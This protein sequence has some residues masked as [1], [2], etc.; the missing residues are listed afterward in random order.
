MALCLSKL[1]HQAGLL[2]SVSAILGGCAIGG[3]SET[4]E[5]V[6]K[7][8]RRLYDVERKIAD[9][10][11]GKQK[12]EGAKRMTQNEARLEQLS[13]DVNQLKGEVDA[14]R[15]G[16]TMGELPGSLQG[17]DSLAKSVQDLNARLQ[18]MEARQM[19]LLEL[20]DKGKAKEL[21]KHKEPTLKNFNQLRKSFDD[22]KYQAV[23]A[24]APILLAGKGLKGEERHTTKLF[25][26]DSLYALGKYRD[27]ALEYNQ[28]L[29]VTGLESHLPG[30]KLRLGD[31]FRHLGDTK[32]AL[33]FYR[34]LLRDY[35]QSKEAETAKTQVEKIGS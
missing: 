5:N 18:V 10:I 13:T 7:L 32:A 29:V 24:N 8:N 20:I 15:I 14:L 11:L 3:R 2:L 27:A 21:A 33:I 16:V 30:I 31:C 6:Y 34:E 23:V 26:A 17:A 25:F 28:L 9:E 35:P 19:E 1:F 22:K 12:A 4:E